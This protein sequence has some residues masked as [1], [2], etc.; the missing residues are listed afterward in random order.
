M[1]PGEVAQLKF[2]FDPSGREGLQNKAITIY[3]TD[4]VNPVQRLMIKAMIE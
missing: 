4:P 2:S 3:S 1:Q